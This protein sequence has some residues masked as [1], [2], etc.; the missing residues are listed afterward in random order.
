[1][2]DREKTKR[3]LMKNLEALRRMLDELHE[4]ITEFQK[5]EERLK[6]EIIEY[7]KLSAL[8]RLTA[9][10]AHEIRNPITVIGGL[11]KRLTRIIPD[12]PKAKQYLDSISM[13]AERL[14][15]ILKDVLFFSDKAMLNRENQDINS[16]VRESLD[17]YED[18]CSSRSIVI[19]KM[20]GE[21][22]QIYVDRKQ[23]KAAMENL[24]SNAVDAMPK[25]GE[26][27]ITTRVD[28]IK[29]KNYVTVMIEDTGIGMSEENIG[30][31]FEPFFTT[32]MTGSETGL[33]LS[34]T[35]KIIESHG[36]LIQVNSTAGKG[37]VFNLYFP[38]RSKKPED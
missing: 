13:E 14:E 30:M 2:R 12:E 36:G 21:V 11:T 25:G 33:G 24:I 5:A 9:N 27:V 18:I 32:K 4:S 28:S 22:P 8:G 35:K 37:S 20:L 26:L 23:V 3:Q 1:V 29:G 34:I 10:V 17:L 31:I 19:R 38:Y 16:V 15:E 6:E 7:E